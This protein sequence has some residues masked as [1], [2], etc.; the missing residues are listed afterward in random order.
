MGFIRN[1]FSV[2]VMFSCLS[3]MGAI[4]WQGIYGHRNYEFREG[5]AKRVAATQAALDV[6]TAQRSALEKR[7]AMLRPG[8]IDADLVDE[9]VR[10]DLNMGGKHDVIVHI[11]N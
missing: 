3:L 5:L 1:R 11:L 10:H 9:I 6:V 8:S 2:V 7:V 4:G